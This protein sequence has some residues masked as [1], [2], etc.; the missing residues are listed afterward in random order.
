MPGAPGV[1]APALAAEAPISTAHVVVPMVFPVIGAVN[2]T[3]TFLACRD[4][5]TR[6]HLG[7]DIMGYKMEKLIAT[8][9][10]TVTYLQRET[11][12]GQGNYLSIRSRDGQWTT[13]YLHINNDTPGTD[14]ARG[15]ANY[16]FLPGLKVGSPVV[17]G[18]LVGF[19][20]DSG[21]AESTSAHLHFELR[22]GDAWSGTVYNP[23]Y[24]INAAARRTFTVVSMPHQ[25]GELLH[26]STTGPVYLLMADGTR[27]LVPPSL[28]A[29]YGWK[30]NDVVLVTGLEMVRYPV[31][32]T[33]PLRNGSVVYGSDGVRW[34]TTGNRRYA[35]TDYQLVSMGLTSA[36]A[37]SVTDDALLGTPVA[38]GAVPGL[39][40]RDGAFVR[41][42]DST[43]V[44]LI[45][46]STRR[47]MNMG[48]FG[49]WAVSAGQI[50]VVTSLTSAPPA[51]VVVGY[52]DG[53]IFHA[54][55]GWFM[56]V[57]GVRRQ[58]QNLNALTYYNWISKRNF[59][60]YDDVTAA[61]PLGAPIA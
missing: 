39:A 32:A 47:P 11:V 33:A 61:L 4:G 58:I 38:T 45:D 46:R 27:R 8:F 44:W 42:Y 26:W 18:Q 37:I 51:G 1:A 22:N 48:A 13:N 14:D 19:M 2:Y 5:C 28:M 55:P 35:V 17:Q 16:A 54:T 12:A 6:R 57:G 50:A 10:G 3:D 59:Y 30:S 23:L 49:W 34:A 21:N 56:M 41:Q 40:W 31:G 60:L 52:Q 29:V 43:Q 7:Q 9:D 36:G 25:P 24:S 15:T 53:T 20:G